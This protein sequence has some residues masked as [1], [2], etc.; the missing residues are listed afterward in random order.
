MTLGQ[1]AS[2]SPNDGQDDDVVSVIASRAR[3]ATWRTKMDTMWIMAMLRRRSDSASDSWGTWA[4]CKALRVTY[5]SYAN[6][7]SSCNPAFRESNISS[8]LTT[9]TGAVVTRGK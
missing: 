5:H 8:P 6:I 1:S 9:K 7:G 3:N 2:I 4:S